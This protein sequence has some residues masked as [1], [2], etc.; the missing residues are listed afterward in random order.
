MS[1]YSGRGGRDWLRRRHGARSERQLPPA[2][3]GRTRWLRRPPVT[4]T[5]R[6]GTGCGTWRS[7]SSFESSQNAE[8]YPEISDSIV[9]SAAPHAL[10][11]RHSPGEKNADAL[12]HRDVGVRH[13]VARADDDVAEVEV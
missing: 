10:C 6:A 11:E 4:S 2:S 5:R 1:L 12:L 13:A 7:F 9:A 8:L 3:S